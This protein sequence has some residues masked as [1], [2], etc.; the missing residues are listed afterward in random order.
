VKATFD[1][2]SRREYFDAIRYYSDHAGPDVAAAFVREFERVLAAAQ[3]NPSAAA[4][5]SS[6]VGFPTA[7]FTSRNREA[8]TCSP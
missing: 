5:G 4:T 7:S 8:C 2:D 6:F 1:P 3:E